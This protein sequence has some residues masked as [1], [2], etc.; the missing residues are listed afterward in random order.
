ML[1][2]TGSKILLGILAFLGVAFLGIVLVFLLIY[3]AVTSI[4]PGDPSGSSILM[5]ATKCWLS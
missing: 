1:G 3:R 4:E 2:T 5:T